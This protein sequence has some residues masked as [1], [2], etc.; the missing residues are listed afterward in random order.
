MVPVKDRMLFPR[1]SEGGFK[2]L[3]QG[4]KATPALMFFGCIYICTA[5]GWFSTWVRHFM[6][7]KE[8]WLQTNAARPPQ[9]QLGPFHVG[10]N[11]LGQGLFLSIRCR[12]ALI[13]SETF[14][15]VISIKTT[16]N[17]RAFVDCGQSKREIYQQGGMFV[18]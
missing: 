5:E 6:G 13:P 7:M 1:M 4:R 18:P 16:R 2:A 3:V 10:Y 12:R 17:L 8:P 9:T 15:V 14:C 11:V